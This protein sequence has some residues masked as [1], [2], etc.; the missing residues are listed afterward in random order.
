MQSL[1]TELPAAYATMCSVQIGL[2]DELFV[3]LTY[4][5]FNL[6]QQQNTSIEYFIVI[7]FTRCSHSGLFH[8][9]LS[10]ITFSLTV[11]PIVFQPLL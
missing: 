8:S 7:S 4:M 9:A 3:T 10:E 6:Q 11:S 5:K 2:R 1:S